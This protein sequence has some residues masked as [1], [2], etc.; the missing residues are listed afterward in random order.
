MT[1]EILQQ[2]LQ[3]HNRFHLLADPDTGLDTSN[4][5]KEEGNIYH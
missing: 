5:L 4:L 1:Q 3:L 2:Q